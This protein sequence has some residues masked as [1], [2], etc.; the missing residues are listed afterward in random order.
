M[1]PTPE[2]II[3]QA[4][5]ADRALGEARAAVDKTIAMLDELARHYVV[6]ND[7]PRFAAT[8]SA[9]ATTREITAEISAAL[10]AVDRASTKIRGISQGR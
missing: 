8:Q 6:V 1:A 3:T 9:T 7:Q 5:L 4:Q 2:E 10:D